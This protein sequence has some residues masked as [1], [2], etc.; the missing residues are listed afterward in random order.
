MLLP[1]Y[2]RMMPGSYSWPKLTS[3]PALSVLLTGSVTLES[4]FV[5]GPQFSHLAHE[6]E[7]TSKFLSRVETSSPRAPQKPAAGTI[8]SLL[9]SVRSTR[10]QGLVSVLAKTFQGPKDLEQCLA[11]T[12]HSR[13]IS[14]VNKRTKRLLFTKC[15][16]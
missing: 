7:V 2:S 8:L 11:H 14:F 1:S 15:M 6:I 13:N 9:Y 3:T 5:T 12:C 16:L 4:H 10:G